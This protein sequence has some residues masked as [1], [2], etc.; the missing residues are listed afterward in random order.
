MKRSVRKAIKIAGAVLGAIVL[1]AAVAAL[2]VLF[3]KPLVRKIV[4]RE[5][6]KAAGTTARFARLDYS[7]FPFRVSIDSL[8]L[9]REDPFQKLVVSLD[10]LE[11]AGSLRKLVRGIKP[12]LDSLEIEG[13]S[14][15][16]EQKEVSEE[17]FDIEAFL[18][19]AS[20]TL[21]W[22]GRVTLTGAR[23]D[24]AFLAGTTSL[25]K[26]DL[27][28]EPDAAED[29]VVYILGRSDLSYAKKDG[30]FDLVCG[31]K[32]SGTLRLASPF[33]VDS[34]F[35]FGSPRVI[36]GGAESSLDALAVALTARLDRSASDFAVSRLEIVAPGLLDLEGKAAGR[37]GHSVY[38]EAEAR[39]RFESLERAAE[40]VGPRLPES[41]RR[42]DLK[43]R[44]ELAGTYGLHR[45]SQ[46]STDD[47]D[48][49]LPLESVELRPGF[50]RSSRP[51]PMRRP[52][53]GRWP[54]ARPSRLGRPP[55]GLRRA[56]RGRRHGRRL[57]RPDR[58]RRHARIRGRLAARGALPRARLRCLRRKD[59][60]LRLCGASRQGQHRSG[61]ANGR[62]DL[63]RSARPRPL[64]SPA[65]G[66]D[67]FRERPILPPPLRK[68]RPRPRRAPVARFAL[69]PGGLR[70]LG[71][72]RDGRPLA[73][74]SPGKLAGRLGGLGDGLARRGHFQRPV[75]HDRRRGPRSDPALRRLL[76]R[77]ARSCPSKDLSPSAGASRCGRRS[78]SPGASSRSSFPS[79]GAT[80]PPRAR[81]TIWP[82]GPSCPISGRSTRP[83]RPMSAQRLRSICGPG[84][85]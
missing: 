3:D 39:A 85:T 67:R 74:L 20:D 29:A 70:R 45:T 30:T 7:L 57:R 8:E 52:D 13:L 42:L 73:R 36:A 22:A 61:P 9:V 19:Q 34:E 26:L 11:A 16:L 54:V 43:G 59:A 35:A 4:R 82:P 33:V 51:R 64:A 58:R 44:A 62:P 25:D 1:L 49:T 24:L 81:S 80:I 56:R 78:I 38:V 14:L 77:L 46:G 17:P 15:R 79:Q 63:A 76:L 2:L 50:L 28:L 53:R 37:F 41:L 23:L 47:V 12:A 6:N 10:R 31:L 21:A 68:P 66:P 83:A 5:L 75:L 71:P 84:P 18:L 65:V 69:R 55:P 72:G 40:L 32:S 60:L 48:A 27:T